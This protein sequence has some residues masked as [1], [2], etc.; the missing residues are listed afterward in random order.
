MGLSVGLSVRPAPSA[1]VAQRRSGRGTL[2]QTRHL[3]FRK[4]KTEGRRPRGVGDTASEGRLVSISVSTLQGPDSGRKEKLTPKDRSV[5]SR[6]ESDYC[7][8]DSLQKA[9]AGGQNN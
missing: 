9:G 6:L 7:K 4:F 5:Q 3:A 1:H 8:L 2:Q